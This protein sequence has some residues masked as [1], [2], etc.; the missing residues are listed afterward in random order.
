MVER[1]E[2]IRCMDEVSKQDENE[3]LEKEMLWSSHC[4]LTIVGF[5]IREAAVTEYLQ[6][7]VGSLFII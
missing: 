6:L 5:E 4:A 7:F 1:K 2:Q 3:K